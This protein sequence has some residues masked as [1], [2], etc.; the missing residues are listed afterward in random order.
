MK[1][2]KKIML[3]FAFVFSITTI[4]NINA[5]ENQE[6]KY[7]KY[8]QSYE[9]A[10]SLI[11]EYGTRHIQSEKDTWNDKEYKYFVGYDAMTHQAIYTNKI[12]IQSR[13]VVTKSIKTL[14]TWKVG[15][16]WGERMADSNGD[17]VYC[18]T[19]GAN[20]P[21]GSYKYVV[22]ENSK[23]RKALSWGFERVKT[24]GSNS[25]DYGKTQLALWKGQGKNSVSSSTLGVYQ[26]V[27]DA[28]KGKIAANEKTFKTS[29]S[30]TQR[31]KDGINQSNGYK[32]TGTASYKFTSAQMKKVT[33]KGAN[34]YLYQ[35]SSK[36]WIKAKAN[37]S[38]ATKKYSHIRIGSKDM[39]KSVT[40]KD[41]EITINAPKIGGYLWK[42]ESAGY[43]NIFS[44]KII[45][46]TTKIDTDFTLKAQTGDVT[47]LKTMDDI[48]KYESEINVDGD[49]FYKTKDGKP[50]VFRTELGELSVAEKLRYATKEEFEA[51]DLFG[52]V[53]EYEYLDYTNEQELVTD[54]N[55][56]NPGD[57]GYIETFSDSIDSETGYPIVVAKKDGENYVYSKATTPFNMPSKNTME[58]IDKAQKDD[59]V[60]FTLYKA[61]KK[62]VVKKG[63]VNNGELTFTGLLPGTYYVKE[64]K[65][66]ENFNLINTWYKAVV[67][68][69]KTTTINNSK[70]IVNEINY[71]ELYI[72]KTDVT[73]EIELDGAKMKLLDNEDREIDEWV[74]KA[75]EPHYI[76]VSKGTYYIEEIVAPK[77]REK[78][79]TLIPVNVDE[80]GQVMQVKVKNKITEADVETSKV[81]QTGSKELEGAKM[82]LVEEKGKDFTIKINGEEKVVKK[83]C[84][85]STKSAHKYKLN[86]GNYKITE[87]VAPKG[88]LKTTTV[89]PVKVQKS[90]TIKVKVKNEPIKYTRTGGI[91]VKNEANVLDS[92]NK[93]FSFENAFN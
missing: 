53:Y 55:G 73:G 38:Y 84:W 93:V 21:V 91:S 5:A 30:G 26:K 10:N 37:T 90:G 56:V 40:I 33:D 77:G 12:S 67:S 78:I 34:I 18:G 7:S 68:V 8:T 14:G 60:E 83:H 65:T 24:S 52:K 69:G 74:S 11:E 76:K 81:D 57:D 49:A 28:Y 47:V 20:Y 4:V 17:P 72:S 25:S 92:L 22:S 48:D 41:I 75:G 35:V 62:S 54:I 15:S 31:V 46:P 45:D 32:V 85:T 2:I 29:K 43:Q 23:V 71:S 64:T 79:T 19:Y 88:Y 42:I 39:S 44:F 63:T 1:N 27:A 3:V 50:V 80:N 51:N 59:G 6:Y 82:C 89:Y 61:D 13:A 9:E 58:S 70:A 87:K 86:Y 36:K 66:K 16:Y